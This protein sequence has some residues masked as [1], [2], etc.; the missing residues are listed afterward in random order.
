MLE[1]L[2]NILRNA[3]Y[4]SRRARLGSKRARAVETYSRDQG[5]NY[6]S[7]EHH[8]LPNNRPPQSPLIIDL[9]REHLAT[10]S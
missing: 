7:L 5:N 1:T 9:F 6:S 3:N 2:S 10:P 8:I 4:S